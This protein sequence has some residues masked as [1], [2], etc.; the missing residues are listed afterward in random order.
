MDECQLVLRLD[1]GTAAQRDVVLCRYVREYLEG[2]IPNGSDDNGNGLMDE[3][4]FSADVADGVWTLRLTV[5]RRDA[6]G[7]LVTKTHETSVRPRN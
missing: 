2:E 3:R 6:S 5:E 1:A 4:G 7:R